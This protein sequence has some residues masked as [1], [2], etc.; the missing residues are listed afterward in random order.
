MEITI[1]VTSPVY[2]YVQIAD[3]LR[4]AIASGKITDKLPSVTK[5]ARDANVAPGT[6]QRALNI[7]RD[8]GLIIGRPGLGTFVRRPQ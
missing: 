3:Q 4:A 6:A 5:I 8:E 2:P 7:L 1:D